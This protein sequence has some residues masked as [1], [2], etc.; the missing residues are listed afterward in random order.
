MNNVGFEFGRGNAR[1]YAARVLQRFGRRVINRN[2]VAEV[3]MTELDRD[4][5]GRPVSITVRTDRV[6]NDESIL[7]DLRRFLVQRV[8]QRVLA[9]Y[10]RLGRRVLP[11]VRGILTVTKE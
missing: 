11:Y 7:F 6:G 10:R 5:D 3:P 9:H 8:E 2:A 1:D 4:E